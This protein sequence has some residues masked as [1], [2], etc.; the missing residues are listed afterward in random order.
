MG[1]DGWFSEG[2]DIFIAMEYIPLGDL[3]KNLKGV[4][5]G[6]IRENEARDIGHQILAAIYIMHRERFVHRDLK[7]QV[8]HPLDPVMKRSTYTA[9]QNVLV[10]KSAPDWWVKVADFGLSKRLTESTK[11][12]TFAGSQS[13]M[14]PEILGYLKSCPS[15]AST[16]Y[17]NAVDIWALGCIIYRLVAGSVP[18]SNNRNL[19]DYC[20]DKYQFPGERLSDI[21]PKGSEFIKTL[22]QSNPHDR[23]ST[24][25]ALK[26]PW[27]ADSM[28]RHI[29]Y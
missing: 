13:Y 3:E 2:F 23:P 10:V 4:K 26:H 20:E 8:S 17:T 27:M 16:G 24:E 15:Q 21:T 1:F 29:V 7:P 22:L 5:G 9:R 25:E 19:I 11:F 28:L 18:F 12:C 14:A 6:K